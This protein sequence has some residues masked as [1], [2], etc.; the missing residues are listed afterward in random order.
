MG[1]NVQ[2]RFLPI[3]S[4]YVRGYAVSVTSGAASIVI[5]SGANTI[6]VTE[7]LVSA[8]VGMT[9]DIRSA[10]T[11]MATVYLGTSGG[12]VWP[13]ETPLVLNSNQ[14]LTFL[15]SVSGSCAVSAVGYT[16]S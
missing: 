9:V 13:M 10:A 12:F 4:N 15:Q 7:I 2:T 8:N 14:S 11:A 5:T 16:V 3:A 1:V 6:C